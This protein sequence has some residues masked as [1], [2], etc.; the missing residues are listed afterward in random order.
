MKKLILIV[1]I[2]ALCAGS[3]Q[4][5]N[6][7]WD[8]PAEHNFTVSSDSLAFLSGVDNTADTSAAYEIGYAE[9]LG[10]M[11]KWAGIHATD[12]ASF[13]V[14]FQ[15]S[16]TGDTNYY[17]WA[18]VGAA[19]YLNII[20]SDSTLDKVKVAY[21]A[22]DSVG[23]GA[24]NTAALKKAMGAK[25]IRWITLHFSQNSTNDDSCYI[26]NKLLIKE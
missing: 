3:A 26:V 20:A 25:Y 5:I 6:W 2:L 9:G 21:I 7:P 23:Y 22:P 13:K 17:S 15:V 12:S 14:T 16:L 10:F 24:L 1:A 11:S 19:A 4:A 8:L 18:T